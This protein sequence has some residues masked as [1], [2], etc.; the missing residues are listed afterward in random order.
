MVASRLRTGCEA[1]IACL[2]DEREEFRHDARPINAGRESVSNHARIHPTKTS[3]NVVVTFNE[4]QQGGYSVTRDRCVFRYFPR[5]LNDFITR[6]T[7]YRRETRHWAFH[8]ASAVS[9][10]GTRSCRQ[11][12]LQRRRVYRSGKSL[13]RADD[14][15]ATSEYRYSIVRWISS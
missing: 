6:L 11:N 12:R 9:V 10:H 14:D 8:L 1:K 4:Q 7:G 13:N 5:F 2:G 15:E 3:D